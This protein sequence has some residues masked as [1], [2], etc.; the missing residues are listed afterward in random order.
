MATK[1]WREISR[2]SPERREQIRAQARHE[3]ELEKMTLTALRRA[4]ALTQATVAQNAE[5][6]QGG[7]SRLERRTDA[8]IGTVR[9][10]VEAMGGTL[11]MVVEFPDAAPVE[12]D[13]F[14]GERDR[15]SAGHEQPAFRE[16]VIIDEASLHDN[17][18]GRSVSGDTVLRHVGR[19]TSRAE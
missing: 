7:V 2:L 5:M 6:A 14:A 19:Q 18:V 13:G 11:R 4:R 1:P 3:L 16:R 8:Y 15:E 9:R 17:T 12:I 10:F